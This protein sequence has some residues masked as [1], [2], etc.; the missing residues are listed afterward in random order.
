M[1]TQVIGGCSKHSGQS[2]IDCPMCAVEQSLKT[3]KS[4]KQEIQD[5]IKDLDDEQAE[6]VLYFMAI[7]V[8]KRQK[9]PPTTLMNLVNNWKT[10]EKLIFVL[11]K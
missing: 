9:I 7:I 5:L 11:N 3:D 2:F 10:L 1:K 4:T 6:N 8:A